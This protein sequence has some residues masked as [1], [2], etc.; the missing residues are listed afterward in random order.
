MQLYDIPLTI[1]ELSKVKAR[2]SDYQKA[3]TG[4]YNV[5]QN[6]AAKHELILK[7]LVTKSDG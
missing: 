3:G 7:N 5:T 4:V 1:T 2:C 6:A